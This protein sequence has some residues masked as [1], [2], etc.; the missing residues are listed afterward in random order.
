MVTLFEPPGP[1]L[2]PNF[3]VWVPPVFARDNLCTQ[4]IWV[5]SGGAHP[6]HVTGEIT[7]TV[8]VAE[9]VMLPLVPVTLTR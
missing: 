8:M 7:L 5:M 1:L 2:T 3:H 9:W 4:F 6:G